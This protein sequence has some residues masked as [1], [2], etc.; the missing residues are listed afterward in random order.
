MTFQMLVAVLKLFVFIFLL[1]V[2][3][4]L[5]HKRFF[6]LDGIQKGLGSMTSTHENL[7]AGLWTSIDP[8]PDLCSQCLTPLLVLNGILE[9]SETSMLFYHSLAGKSGFP[10]LKQRFSVS[11]GQRVQG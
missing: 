9:K 6:D 8:N 10:Y 2:E 3:V 11:A 1:L 7:K 4:W 5:F